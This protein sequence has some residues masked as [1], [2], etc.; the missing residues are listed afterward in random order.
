MARGVNAQ[1]GYLE[2]LV[3]NMPSETLAGYLAAIGMISAAPDAPAAVLWVVWAIF[4]ITTPIYLWLAKPPS[5]TA[6]R[7]WW[8]VWIFSPISFF[9]WSMTTTGPWAT[10]D[11]AGLIGGI[12]VILASV[13]IFPLVSMAIARATS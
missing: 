13:V 5:E 7:P 4:L 1:D 8:Q 2:A 11:K 3:K 10:V 9:I 6:P 12:G